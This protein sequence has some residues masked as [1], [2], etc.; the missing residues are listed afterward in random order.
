LGLFAIPEEA[1]PPRVLA[2]AAARRRALGGAEGN[3]RDGI[4]RLLAD[5]ALLALHLA[6]LP[7]PRRAGYAR[8]DLMR[9]TGMAKLAA[10]DDIG[11]AL[12]ILDREEKLALLGSA[13]SVAALVARA[14]AGTR[15]EP[16]SRAAI[17]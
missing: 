14:S 7:P 9:A 12:A 11:E 3:E 1:A 17:A 5:D 13:A 4:G 6:L 10:V 2:H 16:A 15:C 8:V